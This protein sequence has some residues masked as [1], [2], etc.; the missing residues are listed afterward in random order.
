LFRLKS[1]A[2]D[3]VGLDLFYI[4]I[5]HVVESV[6]GGVKNRIVIVKG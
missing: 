2:I 4:E 3:L 1:E 6:R 5:N